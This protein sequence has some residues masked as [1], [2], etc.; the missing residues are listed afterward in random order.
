MQKSRLMLVT[1]CLAVVAAIL[2][3]Q[4]F[5]IDLEVEVVSVDVENRKMTFEDEDGTPYVGAV[6]EKTKLKAKKKVF[7][8]KLTLEDIKKGDKVRVKLNPEDSRLL[9]VQLLK[10]AEAS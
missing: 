10:R 2:P 3:A 9:E 4:Q 8:G 1:L 6:D 5:V 7:R